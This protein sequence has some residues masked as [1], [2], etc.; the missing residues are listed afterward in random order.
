MNPRTFEDL[1]AY[2]R[3]GRLGVGDDGP[4]V[5]LQAPR[6]VE[7]GRAVRLRW[8]AA[9]AAGA[10]LRLVSPD[11]GVVDEAV[12]LSGQRRLE[13]Q[14]LGVYQVSLIAT[15]LPPRPGSRR[16]PRAK[17][18]VADIEVV[19]PRPT[20]RLD[21]PATATLG[22]PLLLSWRTTEAVDV[23]LL[24]DGQTRAVEAQ[25]QL[26]VHPDQLGR[27]I[28]ALMVRGPGGQAEDGQPVQVVAPPVII[29]APS[30]V[31]AA[32]GDTA[33][34][35]YRVT[36]ARAV[37]LSAIDRGERLVPISPSGRIEASVALEPERLRILAEGFD[38]RKVGKTI[39]VEPRLFSFPSI[40]QELALLEGGFS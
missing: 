33:D 27:Y 13:P 11:G 14:A 37:Y 20:V 5:S 39:T 21:A 29:T 6:R 3:R 23:R 8:R 34:I 22:E 26:V 10:V 18:V 15:P 30:M 4:V 28:I 36:G 31:E 17:Q 9:S 25:G 12:P 19:A 40:D 2:A 35:V 1:Q 38:G 16:R 32:V 24:L 7:R